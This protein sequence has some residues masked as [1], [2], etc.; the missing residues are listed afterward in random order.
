MNTTLPESCLNQ[1]RGL[2][3]FPRISPVRGHHQRAAAVRV[4]IPVKPVRRKVVVREE[5]PPDT[6]YGQPVVEDAVFGERWHDEDTGFLP[7]AA[8]EAL[9]MGERRI[10][11]GREVACTVPPES[12]GRM[13][14]VFRVANE[15]DVGLPRVRPGFPGLR[16][17]GVSRVRAQRSGVRKGASVG[18]GQRMQIALPVHGDA[19][20]VV[21]I[22]RRGVHSRP[23]RARPSPAFPCRL[24][25]RT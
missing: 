25:R 16:P 5:Q 1:I 9:L 24:W 22:V 17:A 23:A 6:V 4:V 3:Q 15:A 19:G 14:R 2:H 10:V 12:E 20:R 13:Q 7:C 21:N 18:A 8:L 11:A